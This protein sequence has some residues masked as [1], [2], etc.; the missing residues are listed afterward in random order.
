VVNLNCLEVAVSLNFGVQVCKN[1]VMEGVDPRAIPNAMRSDAQHCLVLLVGGKDLL[2]QTD[3]ATLDGHLKARVF[4]DTPDQDLAWAA[5]FPDGLD[6]R[7]PE[8]ATL[9]AWAGEQGYDPA[10]VRTA[11]RGARA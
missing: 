11:L 5:G 7:Y 4:L 10:A 1:V 2:V 3:D 6:R 8:V 9:Y